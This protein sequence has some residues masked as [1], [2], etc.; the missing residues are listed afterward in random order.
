MTNIRLI[1]LK[2]CW[3][4]ITIFGFCI[5]SFAEMQLQTNTEAEQHYEKAN[6]LYKLADYDAAI[7]E[8]EQVIK[9]E[10]KSAIA[11]NAKYWIGQIYFEMG[12]SDAALSIFQKI[13]DEFPTSIVV[14][15]TRIMIE[16]VLQAKKNRALFEAA[17]KGD[18][19]QV[20]LLIAEGADI[21][22]SMGDSTG[23]WTP[24]LHAASA[25]QAQVVK[26]LLQQGAKVDTGD[27]YG[28]T[29]L[30]YA[31]WSRDEESV[32]AIISAGADTNK[33]PS[34]N[35]L[36]PLFYAVWENYK[37][38]IKILIDAEANVNIEDDDGW[39]PLRYAALEGI[40]DI[41]ELF[42]DKGADVPSF[43]LAAFMGDLSRVKEFI[44][45]GTYVD[46]KDEAG[47]TALFWA[48][49]T[50]QTE[51]A[52]FLVANGANVNIKTDITN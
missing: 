20:K 38:G 28:Y 42:V 19:E 32:K 40:Q 41:V 10:P 48:A 31:L 11:Q 45:N 3:I 34:E 27:L 16:R 18:V 2:T 33:R 22:A 8:F 39:T 37:I 1:S 47:W 25:G 36:P 13:I 35:D 50:G 15:S 29:P 52:K 24:L 5:L 9:L 51:V 21:N 43:H 49:S 17:K 4:L 26:L 23:P 44:E 7:T 30:F 46:T 12:Q 6:E 14:P